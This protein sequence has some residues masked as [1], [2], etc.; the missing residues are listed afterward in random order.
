MDPSWDA[1]LTPVPLPPQWQAAA[2]KARR[3][4]EEGTYRWAATPGALFRE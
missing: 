3:A 2:E 4:E 1:I